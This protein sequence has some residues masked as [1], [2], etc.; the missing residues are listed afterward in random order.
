LTFLAILDHILLMSALPQAGLRGKRR[1]R[2]SN[3]ILYLSGSAGKAALP[4]V[5]DERKR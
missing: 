4:E 5:K 3:L 2:A 1:P